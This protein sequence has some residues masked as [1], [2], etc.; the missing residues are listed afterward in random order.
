MKGRVL[1]V[2]TAPGVRTIVARME[3][4]GAKE[5]LSARKGLCACKEPRPQEGAA[6]PR[7]RSCGL[8]VIPEG[9]MPGESGKLLSAI[10]AR[11]KER[12]ARAEARKDQ[13]SARAEKRKA[14]AK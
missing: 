5:L 2:Q 9:G 12:Y 13:L 1:L 8:P 11:M 6:E 4:P 3:E 10:Q 7:C 14:R